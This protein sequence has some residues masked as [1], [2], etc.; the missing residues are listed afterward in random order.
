MNVAPRILLIRLKSMGDVMFTLPA[1][2]VV[3]DHFPAARIAFLT[4]RENMFLAGGFPA[5]DE[6]ISL[7]RAAL[8]S[9]NPW[10]MAREL[11][12]LLRRLR[13]GKYSLVLDFQ[14]YGETEFLALWSGAPE[15]WGNVYK[16]TRGRTYTRISLRDSHRHPAEWNLMLVQ[17]GGLAVAS[18]RNEFVLPLAAQTAAREFFVARRLDPLRPTLFLQPFTSTPKK[19]WP[20]EHF[21]TLARSWQSRGGQVIIGGG[22]SEVAALGAGPGGGLGG[23]GGK[24]AAGI[25]RLDEPVRACGGWRHRPVASGRGIGAARRHDHACQR[26]RNLPSLS[27]FKLDDHP[28]GREMRGGNHPRGGPG[29]LRTRAHR[30]S[31]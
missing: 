22:P 5:V 16:P 10:H 15:R 7:D 1:V 28:P 12:G 25:R 31:R 26:P 27:A 2:N 8:R 20:L 23:G 30:I 29:G 6:V 24:P 11:F 3:R 13:V 21:L 14:G 19:D 18:L 9:G 4:S 17:A